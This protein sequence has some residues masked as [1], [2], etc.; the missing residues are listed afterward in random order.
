[1][2]T[3]KENIL[4]PRSETVEKIYAWHKAKGDAEP[5]RGYLGASIIG[6]VCERR[7]WYTFRQACVEEFPGRIYRLFETGDIEEYRVAAELRGIGCTVHAVDPDTNEQFKVSALGGHFSGHMDGAILNLPEAPKSWHV[8]ECKSHNKKSWGDLEKK[9]VLKSKP[10]HYAQMQAYMGLTGMRRAL[11]VAVNKDTDELYAERVKFD[12]QYF[13]QLMAKA[14]RIITSNNIPPRISDR[15]DWYECSFCPAKELCHATTL[16]SPALK[17]VSQ[18]CRQCCFATAH[19]EGPDSGARWTCD[20][21]GKGLSREDQD[22]ACER[23]LF[24]PAFFAHSDP[25]G[26]GVDEQ[27]IDYIDYETREPDSGG[28]VKW[29]QCGGGGWKANELPLVSVSTLGNPLIERAR[30]LG[31][32]VESHESTGNAITRYSD[33][34]TCFCSWSG[35]ASE[36]SVAIKQKYGVDISDE[37]QV[38]SQDNDLKCIAVEF[39]GGPDF[40]CC[41]VVDV[42]VLKGYI[43]EEKH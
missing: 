28:A 11:Y 19:T 24:L 17:V 32:T 12:Q 33:M 8:F 16:Q 25:V 36:I 29:R 1:M 31:A 5:Q 37:S 9:G 40:K 27:G 23:L 20:K 22:R 3:T 18:S 26:Y 14:Y 2:T 4:P 41:A 42:T 7:L 39:Q 35:Q 6:E 21:L 38:I 30:G 15:P 34:E 13:E 43:M 10:K